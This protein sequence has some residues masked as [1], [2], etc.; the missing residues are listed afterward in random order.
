MGK[1]ISAFAEVLVRSWSHTRKLGILN[2]ISVW[3]VQSQSENDLN[4]VSLGILRNLH[5][6][7]PIA[8]RIICHGPPFHVFQNQPNVQSVVHERKEGRTGSEVLRGDGHGQG[9]DHGMNATPSSPVPPR[10]QHHTT[11]WPN[12]EGQSDWKRKKRGPERGV[13]I[14]DWLGSEPCWEETSHF[15]KDPFLKAEDGKGRYLPSLE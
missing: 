11:D 1:L 4:I 2:G 13:E 9:R 15:I 10:P 7:G 12:E 6:L 5:A 14:G 3:L 8:H